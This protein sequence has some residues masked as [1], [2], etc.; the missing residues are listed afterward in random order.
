MNRTGVAYSRYARAGKERKKNLFE[1]AAIK[2]GSQSAA[3][4]E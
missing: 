3:P 2:T 1:W 4:A